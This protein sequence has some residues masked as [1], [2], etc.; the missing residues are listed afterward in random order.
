[1]LPVF[2]VLSLGGFFSGLSLVETAACPLNI[3]WDKTGLVFNVVLEF[4]TEMLEEA[5]N[6]QCSR[7]A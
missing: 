2:L 1:L 6:R 3:F 4:F 5:L 7:I